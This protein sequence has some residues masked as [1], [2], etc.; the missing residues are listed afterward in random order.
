MNNGRVQPH[1]TLLGDFN[2]LRTN[3]ALE[4]RHFGCFGTQHVHMSFTVPSPLFVSLAVILLFIGICALIYPC[5]FAPLS[6]C[7]G[8]KTVAPFHLQRHLSPP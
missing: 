5:S 7:I 4:A 3:S 8:H 2:R 1:I 6:M